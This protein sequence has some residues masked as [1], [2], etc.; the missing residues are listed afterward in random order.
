MFSSLR[1]TEIVLNKL[2]FDLLKQTPS[3]INITSEL[4]FDSGTGG[5]DWYGKTKMVAV[6]PYL[7][8]D[9]MECLTGEGYGTFEA[10]AAAYSY[11]IK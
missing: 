5:S 9:E 10:L 2:F 3:S 11:T 7:S 8:N 1:S 4:A 6:F